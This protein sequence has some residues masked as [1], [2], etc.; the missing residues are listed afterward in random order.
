M[1]SV[2]VQADDFSGAAEVGYCF[3]QHG[4]SAQVVL[5]T[6]D[7]GSPFAMAGTDVVVV[8]SHSRGLPDA[9]AEALVR[10]AFSCP[11]ALGAKV[12]FKKIDSL[13]RGNIGAEVAALTALGFHAVVAGALP[14]L[15]RSVLHGK[16]LVAGTALADTRLWQAEILE[17]PADIPSLF[18][19]EDSMPLQALDLAAVRSGL[20]P[21]KMSAALESVH[22]SITVVD[23]ET[24]HDLQ[25][26]ADALLHLGFQAS[27]RRIVLVGTGGTADVL[28]RRLAA[29][30]SAAQP[31]QNAQSSHADGT[32]S[33]VQPGARPVLAVVGSASATAQAQLERLDT[34]TVVRLHPQHAG[35]NGAYQTQLDDV[36]RSLAAGTDVAVTMAKGIVDP[37]SAAGIVRSLSAFAAQAARGATADLILTGG[38]TAREVLNAVGIQQLVPIAA[39]Q[40]GAVLTRADDGTLVGTKPGS[41]GDELALLQLYNGIRERRGQ[42]MPVPTTSPARLSNQLEQK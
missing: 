27:N 30:H 40:H 26:V 5:G 18:R 10:D 9:T 15:Q 35:V 38:E 14:Q 31:A 28:A 39:V 6:R 12:A 1:V 16:P 13:W 22:P 17:P 2:F 34:F 37:A 24:V 4:F 7:G 19:S 42:S 23:G 11:A 21:Q 25:D 32:T 41:F 36:Q 20:L 33:E 29:Q 8:D 3:V